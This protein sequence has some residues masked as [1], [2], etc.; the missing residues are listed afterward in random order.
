MIMWR[1]GNDGACE[2]KVNIELY[3]LRM[4]VPSHFSRTLG[5]LME[6]VD[7]I[8]DSNAAVFIL[9]L[10]TMPFTCCSKICTS[11]RDNL[12]GLF[13]SSSVEYTSAHRAFRGTTT[14]ATPSYT[15]V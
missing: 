13:Y 2:A 12:F 6:S 11:S 10:G 3:P 1:R 8:H 5:I 9:F 4:Y 7:C 14:T 15:P